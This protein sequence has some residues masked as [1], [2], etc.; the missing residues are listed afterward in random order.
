MAQE[1]AKT[2]SGRPKKACRLPRTAQRE[3]EACPRR[4]S[5]G[6]KT[7][8]EGPPH[9]RPQDIPEAVP[10]DAPDSHEGVKTAQ[11]NPKPTQEGPKTAQESSKGAPKMSFWNTI[12]IQHGQND[13][14]E[15][16]SRNGGDK[17]QHVSTFILPNYGFILS[18]LN[19]PPPL[20]RMLLL[21]NIIAIIIT[22]VAAFISYAVTTRRYDS[23]KPRCT[24]CHT[25][26]THVCPPTVPTQGAKLERRRDLPQAAGY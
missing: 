21:I 22:M 18:H 3:P 24:R 15:S 1:V 8:L 16:F 25:L 14:H 26:R 2:A 13:P 5:Q 7:A 12:Q 10:R 17:T 11:E 20:L 9:R 4:P 6:S 23:P 19:N